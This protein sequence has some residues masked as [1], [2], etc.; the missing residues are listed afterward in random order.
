MF[1]SSIAVAEMWNRRARR[2]LRP[3]ATSAAPCGAATVAPMLAAMITGSMQLDTDRASEVRLRRSNTALSA[4]WRET[5]N[6]ATP[7]W[8]L[9]TLGYVIVNSVASLEFPDFNPAVRAVVQCCVLWPAIVWGCHQTLRAWARTGTAS[10]VATAGA[11]AAAFGLLALASPLLVAV[12]LGER[13]VASLSGLIGSDSRWWG[14]WAANAV[15]PA[16]L[17]LC[18]LLAVAG[19]LSFRMLGS[20]QQL[21]ET[22]VAFAAQERLRALRSQLNPH[23]LFNTLNG[24]AEL[25]TTDRPVAQEL[26]VRLSALL[27]ET[28]HASEH[29]EHTLATEIAH[30]E[31]Y[32][33][34]QELRSPS[35]ITWHVRTEAAAAEATVPSLILLPLVENAVTHGL[36]GEAPQ[37]HVGIESRCEGRALV[38]TVTNTCAAGADRA[39]R[40]RSGLGLRNTLE[41]LDILFG[42]RASLDARQTGPVT[43]QVQ[44]RLPLVRA[45]TMPSQESN[46]NRNR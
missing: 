12:A 4:S 41:R 22:A 35:R 18:C 38:L 25:S 11:T 7:I 27:R 46:A 15:E 8:A 23:F 6:A 33:G 16:L 44:V 32:L 3:K 28:L 19:L 2:L 9:L 31:S 26:I 21:R 29:E 42:S 36:R 24:I 40:E 30:A 13:P 10:A 14:G 20:E 37:L 39:G 43:F 17:Y 5:W 1:T 34:I 45:S